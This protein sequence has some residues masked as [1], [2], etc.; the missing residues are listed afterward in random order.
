MNDPFLYGD[1]QE[2]LVV[3]EQLGCK[4]RWRCVDNTLL[5]DISDPVLFGAVYFMA[6]FEFHMCTAIGS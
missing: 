6:L 5:L 2:K 1:A 3:L 4:R